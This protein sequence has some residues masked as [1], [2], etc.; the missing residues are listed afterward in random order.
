MACCV[1]RRDGRWRS[2][3]SA[4]QSSTS[5]VELPQ[6]I[7]SQ[8]LAALLAFKMSTPISGLS[9]VEPRQTDEFSAREL[10]RPPSTEDT[11][12]HRFKRIICEKY[13]VHL[14]DYSQLYEWSIKDTA[15]FWEEVWL[16]T[17]VKA[18][19]PFEKVATNTCST[20]VETRF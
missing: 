20:A 12:M 6:V 9:D 8:Q 15:H 2:W 14:E 1:H 13:Q 7:A 11:L 19:Q 5:H 4:E 17:G 10:W 16:F 18:S 3:D